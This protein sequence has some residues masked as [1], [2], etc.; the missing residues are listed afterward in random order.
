MH[1]GRIVFAQLMDFLP[2]GEF[3][4]CARLLAPC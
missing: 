1:Q 3:R 4:P 2:K